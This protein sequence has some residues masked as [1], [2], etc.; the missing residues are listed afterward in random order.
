MQQELDKIGVWCDDNNGKI[1]LGK[2]SLKN[3]AVLDLSIS[4]QVVNRKISL[5]YLGLI[6]D[7]TLKWERA[8]FKVS[9][10]GQE[11]AKCG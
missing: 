10:K 7:R 1:H 9:L 2:A 3:R 4:D 8:H 11:R 5:R 6:F